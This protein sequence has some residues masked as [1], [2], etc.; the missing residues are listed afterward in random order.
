MDGSKYQTLGNLK[1]NCQE[2]S[3]HIRKT[4]TQYPQ[5]NAADSSIRELKKVSFR[6]IVRAG[7]PNKIWD[8]ALEYKAYAR[9]N[10]AHD[11][12]I[13][14]GEVTDM[15]MSGETQDTSQFAELAFYKWVTFRDNPIQFLDDNPVLGQYLGPALDV[16]PP[17]IAKIM[18]ENGD[19]VHRYTYDAL[20]ESESQS[21]SHI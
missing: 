19:V 17:M 20:T 10:T 7:S 3:C 12:Y 18:K 13:L 8:G 15:V 16:G 5:Q 1:N 4:D 21:L 14:Q 11:I 9:L 2:A 6:K